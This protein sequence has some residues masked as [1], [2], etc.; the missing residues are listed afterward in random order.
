MTAQSSATSPR[1]SFAVFVAMLDIWLATAL[2][3]RE[4]AI[5]KMA[6][7]AVVRDLLVQA[8]LLTVRWK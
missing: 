1:T 6:R 2:T 8:M 7:L 5:G 3:A 4:A